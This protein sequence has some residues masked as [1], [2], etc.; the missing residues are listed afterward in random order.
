MKILL[1]NDFEIGEL[2]PIVNGPNPKVEIVHA[3]ELG[4]K[5]GAENISPIVK[6]LAA[7]D[8][9]NTTLDQKDIARIHGITQASVSAF[10][11]GYNV[12][13]KDVR[14]EIP[15]I[16]EILEARKNKIK[17]VA[18]SKL[19][20]ALEFFTPESLKQ[21]DIPTAA[22]RL[23]GVMKDLEDKKEGE[24]NNRPQFFIFAPRQRD[25]DSYE[26]ITVNEG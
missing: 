9:L 19:L 4:R 8:S 10:S 21:K 15:E 24:I 2:K 26:V 17:D 3:P 20:D 23:S 25:E 22:A 5:P 14:K 18:S 7:L 11:N 16:V 1:D 6:K 12:T 13:N